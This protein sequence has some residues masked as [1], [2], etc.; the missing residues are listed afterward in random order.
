M[1]GFDARHGTRHLRRETAAIFTAAG[2]ETFLMPSAL[3]TPVLAYAVRAL[4]C[5][6]GRDGHRQPQ[7]AHDNGY[8]VYLGGR[9]VDDGGRGAQIVAPYDAE[10][11][12]GSTTAR[13]WN[14]SAWP[15]EGWTVLPEDDR[16][17]LHSG[18]DALADPGCSPSGN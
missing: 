3:P 18:R 2:I 14:R 13:P 11:P 7:P 10:L 6:S 12:P 16:R 8:K 15:T 5:R 9:A 1:V 4:G 17:R